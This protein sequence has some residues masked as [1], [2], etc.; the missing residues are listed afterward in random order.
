MPGKKVSHGVGGAGNI[1]ADDVEYVDGLNYSPPVLNEKRSYRYST[2]RGGAGN[3]RKYN[4]K[5]TRIAQDVPEGPY[6][7]PRA[8]QAGRGGVGN[9]QE[10]HRRERVYQESIAASSARPSQE[11]NHTVASSSSHHSTASSI[12][13]V[14][15]ANWTKH[16]IFGTKV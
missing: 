11:S 16:L 2:G 7:A 10:W 13:D 9:I 6:R 15:F 8:T 14:G 4:A 5:E 3:I 1:F 12:G